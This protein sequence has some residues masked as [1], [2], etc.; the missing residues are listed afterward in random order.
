MGH[1]AY[2]IFRVALYH[3]IGESQNDQHPVLDRISVLGD[4]PPLGLAWNERA[5]LTFN[6][7]SVKQAPAIG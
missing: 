1:V 4:D 7:P 6:A 5:S 3:P 2:A